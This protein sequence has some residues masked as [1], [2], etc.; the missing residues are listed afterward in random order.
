VRQASPKEVRE[1]LKLAWVRDEELSDRR[2]DARL[3]PDGRVLLYV[4]EGERGVLYPSRE[5]LAEVKLEGEEMM[6]KLRE[7]QAKGSLDPV[8]ELLPPIDDFLRDVE[9]HAKSL[10][11]R[12]PLRSSPGVPYPPLPKPTA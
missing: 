6:A 7:K 9:A 8:K 2:T 10:G 11:K 12:I 5:V 1:L 4:G 3:L